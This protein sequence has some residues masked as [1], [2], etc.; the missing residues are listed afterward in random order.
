MLLPVPKA[1][2]RV[3]PQLL[4]VAAVPR[5]GLPEPLSKTPTGPTLGRAPLPASIS[6]RGL[7]GVGRGAAGMCVGGPGSSP[8][9]WEA[10]W[11][12][13]PGLPVGGFDKAGVH[14]GWGDA[15]QGSYS[16]VYGC[17]S[18]YTVSGSTG[19]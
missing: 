14:R 19:T 11:R 10:G 16:R 15:A 5:M 17:P 6:H 7:S 4:Q 18:D 2:C 13:G 9:R 12:N 8:E 3:Y 1:F